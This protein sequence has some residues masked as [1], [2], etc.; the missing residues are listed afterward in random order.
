MAI[1]SRIEQPARRYR[2]YRCYMRTVS[3]MF[4][5]YDGHVD[6][7][8]PSDAFDDLHRAAV[9]ELRRTSF[10]DYSGAMWLAGLAS[11]VVVLLTGVIGRMTQ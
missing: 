5:Q 2:R 6:V 8:S 3:G 4:A 11:A 10:P 1:G 7:T 9:A